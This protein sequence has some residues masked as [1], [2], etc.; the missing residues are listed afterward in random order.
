MAFKPVGSD[1]HRCRVAASRPRPQAGSPRC[2]VKHDAL[3]TSNSHL[4]RSADI[5]VRSKV[6]MPSRA[7]DLPKLLRTR[8]S[9]L[10]QNE[11]CWLLVVS[12]LA[13]GHARSDMSGRI[14]LL[15][16]CLA[17]NV[18]ADELLFRDE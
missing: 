8:M 3:P 18:R 9:A 14:F 17:L 4:I 5:P 16:L 10:R 6:E 2:P 12:G 1:T 7:L 11:N 15:T 13:Q